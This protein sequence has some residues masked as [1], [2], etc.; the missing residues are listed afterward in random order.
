VATG[1]L[2]DLDQ[3][4]DYSVN[5]EKVGISVLANFALECLPIHGGEIVRLSFFH[6]GG[7]PGF[8][9]FVVD[10]ADTSTALARDD[11]GVLLC[12]LVAPAEAALAT[13][14][15]LVELDDLLGFF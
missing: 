15:L 1:G 4:I 11:A 13:F 6:L 10:E 7:E 3:L 12:R 5:L 8:E 2:C 14:V 9:A